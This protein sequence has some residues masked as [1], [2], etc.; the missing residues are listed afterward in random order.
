MPRAGLDGDAVIS[1]A[2]A[3]ADAEGL[4]ALTLARLAAT[5]GVRAPS[6]YAHV[7]GLADVRRRLA[8]RA[9]SG[10][11]DALGAAAAG[12]ARTDAL[13]AISD[14]YRSY[15]RAH[16][17]TYAAT[18]RPPDPRDEEVATAARRLVDVV[19]AVLQGYGLEGDAAV[20]GV[21]AVR[22]ALHGFVTLEAED[23]F[24]MPLSLDVSFE[25]LVE[26]LDRG[27]ADPAW[28]AA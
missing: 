28:A 14:A 6:L 16:R 7:A 2:A 24:R 25:R 1:A 22:A 21:R 9:V 3:L 12:R 18:Q 19:L 5:L 4:E 11:A 8:I 15:A 20:H 13:R 10:L 17:G 26:V 27:L 23:G